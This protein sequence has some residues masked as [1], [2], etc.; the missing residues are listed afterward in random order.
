MKKKTLLI[1]SAVCLFGAGT[2]ESGWGEGPAPQSAEQPEDG[3]RQTVRAFGG[4]ASRLN[5]SRKRRLRHAVR[6]RR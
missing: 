2:P 3:Y 5:R 6:P 4:K 1:L